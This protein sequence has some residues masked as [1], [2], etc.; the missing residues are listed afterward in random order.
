VLFT[1]VICI[2]ITGLLHRK[3]CVV[4]FEMI[5]W[6]IPCFDIL[7]KSYFNYVGFCGVVCALLQF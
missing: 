4:R 7:L 1:N 5:L 3:H 2:Y 6:T